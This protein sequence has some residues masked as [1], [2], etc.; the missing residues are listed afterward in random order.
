MTKIADV[1]SART[2]DLESLD[3]TVFCEAAGVAQAAGDLRKA[4]D[5]LD[6]MIG[7]RQFEKAAALGYADIASAFIF[8][9]R[10]LGGLQ[11]AD[12]QRHAMISDVA[13]EMQ[14]PYEETEPHVAD[15]LQSS[16]PRG[17]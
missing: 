8:L 12:N 13:Q 4:L 11:A 10:T 6:R 14:W 5:D 16:R 9:Q 3:N 15:Q 2:T 7:D 17:G 1:L